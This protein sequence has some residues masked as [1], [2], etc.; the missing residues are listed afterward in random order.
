M[1]K[2]DSLNQSNKAL[3]FWLCAGL[4]VVLLA[5]ILA[6]D[7]TRPFY[8]LHSWA[9][10]H[11]SW[12]ARN[13][14][15]YGFGYT[16]GMSTWAVGDP[17]KKNPQRY[18]DHPQLAVLATSLFMRVFGIN[19]ANRR[20]T[21]A[22]LS[23]I[24]L[25][26]FLRILRGL[27]DDKTALLAGLIYVLFPISGYFGLGYFHTV[28]GFLAIWYYLVLIRSLKDGPEPKP[29]HKLGLAVSLFLTLQF[30][31]NGF[32]YA[33]AIG[34]H[35]VARCVFRKQLP[36][37]SLLAIL[38]LAPLSSLTLN[39]TLMAA[40][41]GWNFQ[42]II[43]LYK[44]RSAKGEMPEFLWGAWFAKFWEFAI[45][46]FTL[47]IL[48][49]AIVYLTFGQLFVFMET[50]PSEENKRR[51]R[52][53]PQF[54]LFLITPVSQLLILRGALWKHQ[55]WERPFSPFIAIAAALGVM[56][57]G[58]LL[59]KINRRLAVAGTVVLVGVFFVVCV[60]GTNY[61][62]GIRWQSPAKM[63]M[64]KSL[65]EKIPPDK[66]LLSYD[67]F[68]VDQHKSKGAHYRPEIAWHLNREIVQ[69]RIF[70][71]VQKYALTGRY[72][73]Y[74]VPAVDQ[75]SPLIAQL[76]KHYKFEY[77]PGHPEETKNG[78][79]FKRGMMPHMI[80]DLSSKVGGS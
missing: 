73:Y 14:I 40:G 77:V 15:K 36:D 55:T 49:T 59:R 4:L 19:E 35:Y 60:K 65:R 27:L 63:E 28:M 41:Y 5:S 24:C 38:I 62:Y 44:W 12:L 51:S 37:K 39:F 22:I 80:F 72:P 33:F 57:L 46:N 9:A 50:K 64:L 31:W 18:I 21:I 53:F 17:P 20:I 67:P 16:K 70:A 6:R 11:G 43:E 74:L 42:R 52:Q 8:G 26:I 58:D 69:A 23:V 13:H 48:I 71:E 34:L 45:T 54:W 7:I 3:S 66:A 10:A 75:L 79:F 29:V 32:F 2:E 30:G 56:L 1:K 47:P 61:Y 25:V 68:M 78:K 76:R